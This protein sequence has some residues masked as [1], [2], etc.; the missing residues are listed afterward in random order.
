MKQTYYHKVGND[1]HVVNLLSQRDPIIYASTFENWKQG[2]IPKMTTNNLTGA[3]SFFGSHQLQDAFNRRGRLTIEVLLPP[4]EED[5]DIKSDMGLFS[6]DAA[7]FIGGRSFV[8]WRESVV[9]AQKDIETLSKYFQQLEE[10]NNR[11]AAKRKCAG[12][13][14]TLEQAAKCSYMYFQNVRLSDH[15]VWFH[16]QCTE[17]REKARVAQTRD[18]ARTLFLHKGCICTEKK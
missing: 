3:V 14:K 17:H 11:A 1:D 15:K 2:L 13:F 10:D 12:P 16:V 18:D 4:H 8:E 7:A 6:V 5:P 9:Q